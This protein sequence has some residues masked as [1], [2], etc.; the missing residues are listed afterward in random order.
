M[1]DVQGTIPLHP[2][3][4]GEYGVNNINWKKFEKL[5]EDCY[6]NL[7]GAYSDWHCWIKAFDQLKVCIAGERQNDP[8][9]G[10]DLYAADEAADFE[11][12][13]QGWLEDCLDTVDMKGEH[14]L[15]L[16][17]CDDLIGI[18]GSE[19]GASSDVGFRKASALM[20]LDRNDEAAKYSREWIA[21][22]PE[23][24]VAATAGVYAFIK[25]AE[26]DDAEKLILRFI[27]EGTECGDETSPM[28][29][30]ASKFYK[31]IGDNEAAN[32]MDEA[33]EEY[34]KRIEEWINDVGSE[35]DDDFFF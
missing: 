28:F 14:E 13:L 8:G 25:T 1:S 29:M 35:D 3:R 10:E 19:E 26:Y 32:K 21:R 9:F 27:P 20:S 33:M 5:S 11:Y 12:D 2:G 24:L 18:F 23:N 15:L 16:K 17:M 30:A 34:E 4:N 6:A 7:I 31:A 22:E